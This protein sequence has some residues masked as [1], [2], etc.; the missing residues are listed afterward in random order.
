MRDSLF[1][2]LEGGRQRKNRLAVLH[3]HHPASGERAAVPNPIHLVDNRNPR[4]TAPDEVSVHR[5][6]VTFLGNGA[7]RRDQRLPRNLPAEHPNRGLRG[8]HAAENI[9]FDLLQIQQTDQS[10]QHRLAPHARI[11]VEPLGSYTCGLRHTSAPPCLP[12]R[13]TML[14]PSSS[15][16]LTTRLLRTALLARHRA[17]R[18]SRRR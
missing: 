13:P 11:R 8:T 12:P 3:R 7:P 9:L 4:V 18:C 16:E 5:V 10:I 2:L 1:R 6:H 15:S 14:A 17:L